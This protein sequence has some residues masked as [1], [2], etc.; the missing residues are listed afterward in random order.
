VSRGNLKHVAAGTAGAAFLTALLRSTRLRV[1]NAEALAGAE[2]E[3][4]AAVVPLWH[5][6]LLAPTF[7]FRHRDYATMASRSTDGEYI[8]HMLYRW[9]Y[10]V[11]RGSSS[12]GGDSALRELAQLVR[13]GHTAALTAD[14]PRGP[15]HKLKHGVLRLAAMTGAPIVP[16]AAAAE[17][18]WRLNSWDRFMIPQPLSR[19][20]VLFGDPIPV[21]PDLGADD[22][23][24]ES[25]RVEGVMARL[26]AEAEA[27]LR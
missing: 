1:L 4:G 8:T 18:A 27:A 20:V 16:V 15:R 13:E 22:L 11:A 9:G 23:A 17:R 3:F 14:G 10:R 7:A 5:G 19:V 6:Q 26:E 12:R 24:T 2:A 21:R 25:S